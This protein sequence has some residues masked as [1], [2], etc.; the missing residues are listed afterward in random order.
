MYSATD[1]TKLFLTFH[2]NI[3][4]DSAAGTGATKKGSAQGETFHQ[5]INYGQHMF[6]DYHDPPQF[7]SSS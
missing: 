6:D 4:Q 2:M 1:Q 3:V 7:S 5:S